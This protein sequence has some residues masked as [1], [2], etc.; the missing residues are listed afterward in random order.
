MDV[1]FTE[2]TLALSRLCCC[3]L[4]Y[5]HQSLASVD[6]KTSIRGSSACMVPMEKLGKNVSSAI[7][8]SITTHWTSKSGLA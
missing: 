7:T 6:L 3:T 2:N 8:L 4:K 1:L 5:D